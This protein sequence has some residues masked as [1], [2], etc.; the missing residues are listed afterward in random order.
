MV[1][2]TAKCSQPKRRARLNE[3]LGMHAPDDISKFLPELVCPLPVLRANDCEFA[4]DSRF[5][6]CCNL[7]GERVLQVT[8][9]RGRA[10]LDGVGTLQAK[11]TSMGLEL[12]FEDEGCSKQKMGLAGALALFFAEGLRLQFAI[13]RRQRLAKQVPTIRSHPSLKDRSAIHTVTTAIA[14]ALGHLAQ[15]DSSPTII[16]TRR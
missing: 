2:P 5:R 8:S 10:T 11:G 14:L 13:G 9:P 16:C 4:T 7:L 15:H 12:E 1:I 6:R 3:S